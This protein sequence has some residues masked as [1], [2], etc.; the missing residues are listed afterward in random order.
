MNMFVSTYQVQVQRSESRCA[1]RFYSCCIN[2][3]ASFYIDLLQHTT[4][5]SMKLVLIIRFDSLYFYLHIYIYMKHPPALVVIL[6]DMYTIQS[7]SSSTNITATRPLWLQVFVLASQL[8]L[9]VRHYKV[10]YE[11]TRVFSTLLTSGWFWIPTHVI[12]THTHWKLD[13]RTWESWFPKKGSVFFLLFQ[14]LFSS[15]FPPVSFQRLFT[16][17]EWA[18]DHPLEAEKPVLLHTSLWPLHEVNMPTFQVPWRK[19]WVRWT[20]R[21]RLVG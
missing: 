7:R 6:A 16:T 18:K 2:M 12:H 20:H 11:L 19:S 8:K 5:W 10:P 17:S 9:F 1:N 15:R 4:N 13:V 21:A 14:G 3:Q